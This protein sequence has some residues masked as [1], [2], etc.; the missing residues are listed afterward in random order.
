MSLA[1]TATKIGKLSTIYLIGSFTPQVINMLVLPVYTDYLS[2]EQMGIFN[3]ANRVGA[4]LS[5]LIQLGAL[6]GYKSWYFRTEEQLRPQ[7]VRTTQ[8]GQFAVNA[9]VIAALSLVGFVCV[10]SI[11]P[12]LP[13]S[14][15]ALYALW[16]LILVDSLGDASTRLATM[17][18]RLREHA[19]TSVAI[20]FSVYLLQLVFSLSTVLWLYSAGMDDWL[21]FGRKAAV[22]AAAICMAG[23]SARI[24]WKYG[25]GTFDR[26]MARKVLR[27]G[28]Q[29]VP[30]QLSDTLT[31]TANAWMLSTL[32]STAALGVYGVAISFAVLIQMPLFN[33]GD[34]AYPTLSR[35]MG[36]ASDE[37]RRQQSRIYTLTLLIIILAL[38]G[39]FLFTTVGVRVL[40]NP[41]YHEAAA[42]VPILVL[43][44][45]FQ[46]FYLIVAQP[47]SYFGGGLWLSTATAT[48]I[49]AGV[50]VGFWVI[51]ERGMYGAAWSMVVAF[52]VKF[53]VATFASNH[54]YPLRWELSKLGRA[55]ACA[56]AIAW[57]D[58][59]FVDGWLVV[60]R[61]LQRAGSFFERVEW[62]N[63]V[64][65]VAVKLAMLAAMIPL[66]R[67]IGVVEGRE[68]KM[69]ADS[70]RNKWRSLSGR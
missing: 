54:L 35:L 1:K 46:A 60:V 39:Q 20:G 9:V 25:R 16:L 19:K 13:L 26:E 70:V 52:A 14:W 29:F 41:T 59:T 47:V 45:M 32:Y 22:A 28:I 11:L 61:D 69:L 44:W 51:P 56:V 38:L 31:L 65:V 24:V 7:L 15:A 40:T 68:L 10:E 33:F 42:V 67:I 37:S 57:L 66:W 8:I 58:L 62:L 48:S 55:L 21:G 27:T 2:K 23:L 49:A 17:T 5:V 3:L 50:G 64:V 30:H 34:A 4:P 12:G 43:A 36:E 53:A 63:L 6:V 18:T